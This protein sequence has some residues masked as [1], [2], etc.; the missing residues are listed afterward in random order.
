MRR[1]LA[2][3]IAVLAV[4]PVAS[5]PPAVAD[6]GVPQDCAAIPVQDDVHYATDQASAPLAA[7][8]VDD[9]LAR[10]KKQHVRAG[11]G[12]TVA[13]IDSGVSDQAPITFAG[14]ID[15]GNKV[16][17]P[18]DY[19]GTAVAG[20]IAGQPRSRADG[21]TVGI[22]PGARILDVQVY[23]EVGAADDPS[24]PQSPMT[25]ANLRAGLQ[26]V[27]DAVPTEGIRIVNMSLA[28]PHDD[29]IEAQIAQLWSMGVVVVA[30][31]G[32]RSELPPGL[33]DT[34]AQHT[35]GEDAATFI[36]PADY[37]HVLAVNASPQGS[38]NLDPTS[39]V[40][41][42]SSTDVAAPTSGAV[43][44]S[45]R[46]ESCFLADP[47]TS[48]AAAEVSGVLALLQSA[49][50]ESIAASVRRL[51]TTANGRPDIPNTLVGAGEVQAMDALT[52]PMDIDEETGTDVG[53]S[54]VVHEPQLL[55][56]PEEPE[57]VLASTREDAVWWGVL[58]GG[59]L[60]LA[61]LLRPVLARRRRTVSR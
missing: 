47:A 41:E 55:S 36:H 28:I 8:G 42:N 13:V 57:D 2:S 51:L 44:Y 61:V 56:V 48:Y 52:R 6:D 40:L 59:V 24:S 38:S 60:L 9:A 33:P 4:A 10:L 37:D 30:P 20:L 18:S 50:D 1:V 12:V 5:A 45:L 49:Y 3:A 22:A 46:G 58:G 31:T 32:N 35:S 11:E 54:T 29:Q 27:I 26:A 23:D 7:M 17:A 14:H 43:S 53:A 16:P 15:A 25:P 21:G 19:H 34:F 39:W